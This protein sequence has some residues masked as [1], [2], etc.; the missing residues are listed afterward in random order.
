LP[1][2][3]PDRDPQALV[4]G[5]HASLCLWPAIKTIPIMQLINVD[6]ATIA[7]TVYGAVAAS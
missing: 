5:V 6:L 7:V 3:G 4:T 2:L 1:G